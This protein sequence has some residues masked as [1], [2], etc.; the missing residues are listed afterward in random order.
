MKRR[1]KALKQIQLKVT[2]IEAEFYKEIHALECAYYQKCAALY[3]QRTEV[4]TGAREPTDDE[5]VWESDEEDETL[6]TAVKQ[7]L[8]I[9]DVKDDAKE[10]VQKFILS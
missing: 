5:C 9:K 3:E 1:I 4:V 6:S 8:S 7:N 10:C 2:N